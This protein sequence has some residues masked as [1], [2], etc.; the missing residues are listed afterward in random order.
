MALTLRMKSLGTILLLF[1]LSATA[2]A[3]A[4]AVTSVIVTPRVAAPVIRTTPTSTSPIVPTS[5][6]V[7][8]TEPSL[9]SVSPRLAESL[10][11][12]TF[13]T[14]RA[15]PVGALYR[16]TKGVTLEERTLTDDR[17]LGHAVALTSDGWFVTVASALGSLSM[18]E[19]VIWHDGASHL[20]T[21]GFI[22]RINGTAYL[23]I[24]DRDLSTPAFGD[25]D[26]LVVGSE[27]WTERRPGSFAPTLITSLTEGMGSEVLSS[28]VSARRLG[29]SGIT[30]TGDIGSPI[31][32]TRGSLLGIIESA[33]GKPLVAIPAASISASFSSLLLQGVVRHA[34]FGVRGTD[35]TTW[36]IDGD[37]G[38]LPKRGVLLRDDRKTGK[39]AVTAGSSAS[40]AG[41]KSGDVILA[42]EHD[43][44]D[45]SRDLGELISEYRPGTQVTLRVLRDASEVLIPVAFGSATT[46]EALK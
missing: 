2:G 29:L 24:D 13:L 34:T 35:L 31:W 7:T 5:T 40:K 36:K 1:T 25:V 44:L 11:P 18:S 32:D 20:V 10:V 6:A 43:M 22:D 9:V 39:L 30:Q 16:R 4:G 33:P 27:T 26:R 12:S 14:R 17:M 8:P 45:G 28:D 42:V 41:L 3:L 23:K 37:R 21:R 38:A 19:L 46:S 15:S